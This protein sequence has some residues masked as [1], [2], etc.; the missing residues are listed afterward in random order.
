MRRPDDEPHPYPVD[1]TTGGIHLP[2]D[3]VHE[4]F[5]LVREGNRK[6]A[7]RRVIELTGASVQQATDYVET[8][9][10]RR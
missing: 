10:R 6:E 5:H 1:K 9:L 3:T 8:L 4:L 2:S 7:V